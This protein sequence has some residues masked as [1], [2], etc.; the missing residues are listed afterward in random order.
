MI[1]KRSF[2]SGTRRSRRSARAL[3]ALAVLVSAF[4]CVSG[5]PASPAESAPDWLAAAGRVDLGSFGQGSAAVVVGDWTD[6]SV[7]A[8]GRYEMTWRR[9][10]RVLNWQAGERYLKAVGEESTES[11]VT[12]MRSWTIAPSG[13]VSKT[14]KK[15]IV[16]EA[17]YAGFEEFTDVHVKS[18][19]PSNANDGSLIG[20]EVITEGRRAIAGDSFNMEEPIPVRLSELHVSVPSG[21]LRWFTNHPERVKVVS[22][23]STDAVFRSENRGAIPS[24]SDAP[25]FTSLAAFV[26]VNYDPKGASAIQ[27]WAEAGNSYHS[28]FDP[29]EKPEGD[30]ASEVQTLSTDKAEQFAKIDALYS[31]VSR[32][33]RYVA[34]EIGIGGY[35]PRPP[36]DVFKNK[37]GDCKDKATLLISMLNKIGLRAYP[38]LVGT[39][40]DVE[41]Q[42]AAPTLATFD[43]VIVALP[44]PEGLRPAV[45]A[46][47]AYDSKINI[48][49][50]DPTSEYDA[51]GELPEMDQGVYS[52]IAYPDHGDLQRI[53]EAA[54]ERNGSEYSVK[55]AL[56][57]DGTGSADVIA[58]YFGV[59][60]SYRHVFYRN[61]S[62]AEIL[63]GFEARVSSYVNQATFRRASI[64]G[65]TDNRQQVVENFSFNGD[66]SVTKA[67]DSWILRPLVFGEV[68]VP[69]LPARPRELPLDV[70][71]P[72]HVKIDYRLEMPA[73]THV[74]QVPSKFTLKSDFG[75]AS[76]EYSLDGNALVARQW[77]TFTSSR[78]PPDKY[79]EFRAFVNSYLRAA[80]QSVRVVKAAS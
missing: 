50:M 15:D 73:G 9:A 17:L 60:N 57:P 3:A 75:E 12:S 61:R 42:P 27:S 76:I 48:L 67:G 41:A 56:Q 26:F 14:D 46:M 35:Q 80:R 2:S 65:T 70:G 63:K 78:I 32:E 40:G 4:F 54:P 22:Q 38:A 49:W 55:V 58:R 74:E 19:D 59:N 21:S 30:I 1:R 25:P 7:D 5:R 23:S 44:V 39:R 24:E 43:H 52:L 68:N 10:V 47:P 72:H 36:A 64:T 8:S 53:P 66:F 69:D 79:P 45:A 51:I 31:Y 33:I 18:V 16:S 71:A 77:L 37:Y 34:I 6:Y 62:Q 11:K 29:G 28:L 13:R 20:T